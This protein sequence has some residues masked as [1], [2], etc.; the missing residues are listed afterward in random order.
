MMGLPEQA[1]E[2]DYWVTIILQML[3]DSELSEYLIFKGGTSLSKIGNLIERFSED[4]DLAIDYEF[5]GIN[6]EPTKR[7]IKILRKVSSL[8][9][10]EKMVEVIR[11]QIKKFGLNNWLHVYVE[12]DGEGDNTYPEPRHIYIEYKSVMPFF[13]NYL[14]PMIVIETGARSLMEPVMDLRIESFI[15]AM[16]PQ[17]E[18][19]MIDVVIK[20]AAPEKTFL[21]KVFLLHEL[22][23]VERKSLP[24]NRRSRHMYDLYR[25]MNKDFAINAI[26]NDEL[27]E[28]VRHHRIMFTSVMGVQYDDDMR[29]NLCLVPSENYINEWKKDYQYMCE[30]MIYGEKPTFDVLIDKMKEL[31]FRFKFK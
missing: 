4:I 23:S 16:L 10:K 25:M 1:V 24:A 6:E 21:E 19:S 8:F 29:E 9:V 13:L 28:S 22:F 3:F 26:N 11:S 15:E 2:K 5:F 14:K 17:I 12:P 20:T 7:Q 18:T 27:W 30:S 31:E